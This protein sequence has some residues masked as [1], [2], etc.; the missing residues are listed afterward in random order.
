MPDGVLSCAKVQGGLF[1]GKGGVHKVVIAL[2]GMI[3]KGLS[4]LAGV[5]ALHGSRKGEYGWVKSLPSSILF[6]TKF[7]RHG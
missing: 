1:G 3:M 2:C 6:L 4:D 5:D 7:R